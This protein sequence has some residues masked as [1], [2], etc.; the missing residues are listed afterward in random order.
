MALPDDPQ[1]NVTC[2]GV[3]RRMAR[4][5]ENSGLGLGGVDVLRSG[6]QVDEVFNVWSSNQ[7]LVWLV[8][9]RAVSDWA[10]STCIPGSGVINGR[11]I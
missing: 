3:L 4:R 8:V 1:G 10:V 5:L 9:N 7:V 11:L 2:H 6:T